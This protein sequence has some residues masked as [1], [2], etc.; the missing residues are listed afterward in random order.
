MGGISSELVGKKGAGWGSG[1][2]SQGHEM[3]SGVLRCLGEPQEWVNS[4]L[5]NKS[6]LWKQPEHTRHVSILMGHCG[7]AYTINYL[8]T[9]W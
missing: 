1:A 8:N 9:E 2:L 4:A 6:E 5:L 7:T 3:S